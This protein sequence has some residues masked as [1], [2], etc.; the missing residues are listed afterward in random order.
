MYNMQCIDL[1]LA[2]EIIPNVEYISSEFDGGNIC[3]GVCMSGS[4]PLGGLGKFA[5]ASTVHIQH[6]TFT[7]KPTPQIYQFCKKIRITNRG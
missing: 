5:G 7:N 4:L 2:W 6:V 1:F 3:V